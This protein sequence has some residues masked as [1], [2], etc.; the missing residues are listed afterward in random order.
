LGLS[1]FV[2]NVECPSLAQV[3]LESRDQKLTLLGLDALSRGWALVW[4]L[5]RLELELLD[6]SPRSQQL[7]IMIGGLPETRSLQPS[8]RDQMNTH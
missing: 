8:E 1:T 2:Q 6:L 5:Q 4:N 7:E 3:G